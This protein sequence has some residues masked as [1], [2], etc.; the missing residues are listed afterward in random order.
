MKNINKIY[1]VVMLLGCLTGCATPN[2]PLSDNFWQTPHQKIVV[3]LTKPATPTMY[4]EGPEGLADI[5][6]NDLVDKDFYDYL[7]K[8]NMIWYSNLQSTFVNKLNKN[9]M[10]A[11]AY[12]DYLADKKHYETVVAATNSDEIL[13]LNLQVYGAV[14]NYY[15]FIPVDKPK[16]YCVMNGQLINALTKQVL[17]NYNL[18]VNQVVMGNWDQPANYPNFTVSLN[19]A[20]TICQE[21]MLSNFFGYR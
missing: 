5:A 20:S 19:N 10:Q 13:I 2:V 6:I 4:K 7:A 17:W 8:A 1:I 12:P 18:T 14:R 15:G 16:A 9:N 11:Y 21:E 3:V